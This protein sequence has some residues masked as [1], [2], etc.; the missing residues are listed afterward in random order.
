M[1]EWLA[2]TQ[3]QGDIA[4]GSKITMQNW[5]QYKQFMPLGMQLLFEGKYFWKIPA[6]VEMDVDAPFQVPVSKSYIEATEKYGS[7]TRIEHNASGH[8]YVANYSAGQPF[9]NPSGP[10]IGDQLLADNWF[11][12]VPHLYVNTPNNT[13]SACTVDRF[14]N[15]SCSSVAVVY[16]QEGYETDPGVPMNLPEAGDVWF[17]EWLEVQTPEQSRYTANLMVYHKD[18]EKWLDDYVFVPALRRSLR[19]SVT[20]RCAPIQGSDYVQDDYKA[21]GFNGGL[22]LFHAEYLGRRKV[23]GMLGKYDQMPSSHF[24]AEYDMPLGWPKP[25]WGKWRLYDVDI[26]DVR[27]IASEAAG[28]CYGSR[29]MYLD[30]YTHYPIWVDLYDSNLKLWKLQHWSLHMHNIPGIGPTIVNSGAIQLWDIQNDHAT[31]GFE[32]AGEALFNSEAPLNFRDYT[33]YATPSGLMQIMR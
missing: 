31:I 32:T 13:W 5:Q 11:A 19:L 6:D 18:P 3:K 7:Q 33:K 23:I 15:I 16:R 20:A 27:R 9:P 2:A 1:K 26:I 29:I 21:I 8:M 22:A 14:Q 28:Y 30:R 4:P 24:P 17:T 10:E 25:S 12:Y